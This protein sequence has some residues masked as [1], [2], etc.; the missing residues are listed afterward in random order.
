V[1]AAAT[2][3]ITLSLFRHLASQLSFIWDNILGV[4]G[5]R[6]NLA[7][8][9]EDDQIPLRTWANLAIPSTLG[10]GSAFGSFN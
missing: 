9:A 1:T 2:Q 5:S 8:P 10:S 3:I 4:I 7:E 6:V